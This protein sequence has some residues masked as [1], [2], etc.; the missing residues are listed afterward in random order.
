L[1]REV[2]L[3]MIRQQRKRLERQW[4]KIKVGAICSDFL[5]RNGLFKPPH[6][7]E[8]H[9]VKVSDELVWVLNVGLFDYHKGSKG[10][11]E[12]A[13]LCLFVGGYLRIL[14]S[15]QLGFIPYDDLWENEEIDE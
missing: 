8:Y 6:I 3:E 15:V 7:I 14:D 2:R 9:A 1:P 4:N 5:E 12:F 10:H 11:G 13:T